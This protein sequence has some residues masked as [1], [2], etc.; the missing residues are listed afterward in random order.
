MKVLVVGS[1]G[2]EH[3]LAW[4]LS[5]SEEVDRIFAAPGNAGMEGLAE[6]VDIAAGQVDRL[7]EYAAANRIDLTVVGPEVPLVKGIADHFSSEGLRIFGFGASGSRLEGSKVWAKNFMKRNRI[8][9]GDYMVFDSAEEASGY[10]A[11][12]TGPFVIK[13]DGLAAGKGVIISHTVEDAKESVEQ[14]MERREFGDA[15]KRVVIEE[16][17]NGQEVSILAVFDGRDYRLFLPSQDH[18]R[19]YDGD[20]GPNTGGMGAYAPVP[21]FDDRL[22]EQVIDEIIEPTFEGIVDEGLVEGAGV[23]YFGLIISE[24]GP[25]VLEYNCRF[26]DPETQAVLPLFEGDLFRV[27]FE[28]TEGNLGSVKFSNSGKSASCVVLASGGYP[29]SYSKGYRITGIDLAEKEGCMVFHAGTAMDEGELV[30]SGGRVLGVTAVGETL[31]ESLEIVYRGI[32]KI[33]FRDA[34]SRSD[35]GKKALMGI[36]ESEKE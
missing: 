3:A 32:E 24:Q 10:L 7:A 21:F 2:R 18:K 33:S 11:S 19:A 4:K 35:I 23:L 15:G 31:H 25:R 8:P 12:R 22:R 30:T 5:L 29:V 27:M 36:N 17:L 26:G 34:F 6:R 16:F 9:T 28:A 14:I 13:A 1:G 20:S